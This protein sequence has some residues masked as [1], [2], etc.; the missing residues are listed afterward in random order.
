DLDRRV[1]IGM[2]VHAHLKLADV[3]DRA[4]ALHHFVLVEGKAGRG[5]RFGDVTRTDGTEQL[6]FRTRV[7][8][9][10]HRFGGVELRLA[11]FGG[12]QL[13]V[14]LSFVLGATRLE[15]GQVV[16]RGRNRLALRDEVVAPVTRLDVDLVAKVAEV[17][18]FLQKDQLHGKHSNSLAPAGA[19]AAIRC[20]NRPVA[21]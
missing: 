9:Y 15:V 6:S 11:R 5:E 7:G 8:L 18:Y 12:T 21:D 1:D 19:D 16:G 20:P 10:G 13:L 17:L 3:T 2:Q 14:C 4:F